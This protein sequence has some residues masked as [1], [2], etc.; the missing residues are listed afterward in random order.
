M[1]V[2]RGGSLS[3]PA[4]PSGKACADR[5][6]Q[7]LDGPGLASRGLDSRACPVTRAIRDRVSRQAA[8]WGGRNYT[9]TSSH[10]GPLGSP[11][12]PLGLVDIRLVRN[13]EPLRGRPFVITTTNKPALASLVGETDALEI[14]GKPYDLQQVVDAV[15]TARIAPEPL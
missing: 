1:A 12:R 7:P 8:S 5:L 11:V 13:L 4:R 2:R 10:P 6:G 15:R 3:Y 14:S 9:V